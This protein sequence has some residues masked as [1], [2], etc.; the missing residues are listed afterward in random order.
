MFPSPFI[1]CLIFIA[2][3]R[4]QAQFGPQRTSGGENGSKEAL[5]MNTGLLCPLKVSAY[6]MNDPQDNATGLGE[7]GGKEVGET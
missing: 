1:P 4:P 6:L 2:F 3:H 5:D 7:P